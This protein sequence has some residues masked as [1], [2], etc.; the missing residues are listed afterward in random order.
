[1]TQPTPSL[2]EPLTAWLPQQRWFPAKGHDVALERV[3]GIRLEDSAGLAELEVHLIAVSSGQRKDI[4]SVPVSYHSAPV[5]ELA[6]SLL[7]R[8][9]HVQRRC[10]ESGRRRGRLGA[11]RGSPISRTGGRRRPRPRS[12]CVSR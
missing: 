7:G 6:A 1:M 9:Q 10:V 8:V 2:P 5:P 4:I 11:R 3:G 12:P